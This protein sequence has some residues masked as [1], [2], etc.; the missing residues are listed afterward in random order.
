[1]NNIIKFKRPRGCLTNELKAIGNTIIHFMLFI[2]IDRDYNE[3]PI[4]FKDEDQY[5]TY[6]VNR[7]LSSRGLHGNEKYFN[8]L[9]YEAVNDKKFKRQMKKV[10]G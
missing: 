4:K 9:Y 10:L 6:H 8:I 3:L 7:F 2:D 5:I 1:M